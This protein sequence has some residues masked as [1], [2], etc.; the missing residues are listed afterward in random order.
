M[1]PEVTLLEEII[2]R[3]S[4]IRDG[5]AHKSKWNNELGTTYLD[6]YLDDYK[7]RIDKLLNKK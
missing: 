4:I 5:W 3:L 7:I 2:T 1:N 6:M